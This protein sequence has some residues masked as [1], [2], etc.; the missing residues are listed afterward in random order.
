MASWKELVHL[1]KWGD[2]GSLL[3][4]SFGGVIYRPSERKDGDFTLEFES[5][6]DGPS[7]RQIEE[8]LEQHYVLG[9]S[10]GIQD[11]AGQGPKQ[12]K[13]FIFFERKSNGF[14][15]VVMSLQRRSAGDPRSSIR[16]TTEVCE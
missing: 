5:T 6:E 12:Y 4:R 13:C 16:V 2:L 8:A 11:E 9:L 15:S 1:N 14:I 7:V 10:Y 3:A